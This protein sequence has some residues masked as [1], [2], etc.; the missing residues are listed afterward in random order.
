MGGVGVAG[1]V[2][3]EEGCPEGRRF[4]E[5]EGRAFSGTEAHVFLWHQWAGMGK[6]EVGVV[7]VGC[8]G[9]WRR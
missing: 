7:G 1:A 6:E 9:E 2:G 8:R 3:G 4:G 5:E